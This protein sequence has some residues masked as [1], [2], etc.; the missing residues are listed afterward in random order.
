[1][2]DLVDMSRVTLAVLAG[3]AGQRM[4]M[5]KALLRVG[6]T[7]ILK[8]LIERLDWPGPT[9]LVTAPGREH[10]PGSEYF[11]AEAVDPVEG[12]GPLRGVLTAL[13][14]TKSDIVIATT[15]D[16]PVIG[17]EQLIWLAGG[18][19]RSSA[20]G[21]MPRRMSGGTAVVEPFP[22][23]C[24]TGAAELIS[25]RLAEQRRSMHSLAKL[26]EF[27]VETVP[28]HWPADLWTNLNSP[29]DLA[30][31]SAILSTMFDDGGGRAV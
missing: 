30:M 15:V 18:L 5:P 25:R 22:F 29:A 7:P 28:P 6:D 27:A 16:M 3:G 21:L 23:A 31:F 19:M 26:A 8:Y 13:E 24:R 20:L 11:D 4:G 14:N 17:S 12:E 10:P 1:M 2:D 9:L